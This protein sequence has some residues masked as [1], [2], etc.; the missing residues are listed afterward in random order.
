MFV[1][2]GG[3]DLLYY[4]YILVPVYWD[5]SYMYMQLWT[6]IFFS[7]PEVLSCACLSFFVL[8]DFKRLAIWAFETAM[9]VDKVTVNSPRRGWGR[10]NIRTTILHTDKTLVTNEVF[11][12][13][14]KVILLLGFKT[15]D[16]TYSREQ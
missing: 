14:N 12:N 9:F 1:T 7:K 16:I 3:S 13:E 6:I 10:D 2:Y 4:H 11:F 5:T 8:Y 15:M